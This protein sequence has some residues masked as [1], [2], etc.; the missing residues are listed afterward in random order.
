[1][2]AW[3]PSDS[4]MHARDGGMLARLSSALRRLGSSCLAFTYAKL[5]SRLSAPDGTLYPSGALHSAMD[6][7]HYKVYAETSGN[8]NKMS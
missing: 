5:D 6:L 8:R 1:M 3:R 7:I 4:T 2:D